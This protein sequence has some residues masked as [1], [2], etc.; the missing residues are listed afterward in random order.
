MSRLLAEAR[1][2]VPP[3]RPVLPGGLGFRD[4]GFGGLGFRGQ[5]F[6]VLGS[7]VVGFR[8]FVFFC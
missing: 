1:H 5:G 3:G 6:R 8:A 7:R 4:L 2:R